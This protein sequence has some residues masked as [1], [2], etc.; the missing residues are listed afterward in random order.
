MLLIAV[1]F[2]NLI[3]FNLVL[4]GT[5]LALW[6]FFIYIFTGSKVSKLVLFSGPNFILWFEYR[7]IW[8][9]K[10]SN[11]FVINLQVFHCQN[12]CYN[13]RYDKQKLQQ[14]CFFEKKIFTRLNN[15]IKM[16]DQILTRFLLHRPWITNGANSLALP[17]SISS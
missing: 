14:Q 1:F 12:D 11:L 7:K 15:R 6:K 10:N 2:P 9:R 4:C 16:I 8:T 17:C 13:V 5:L 3:G